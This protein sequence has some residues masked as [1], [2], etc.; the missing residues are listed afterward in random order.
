MY[1]R[2]RVARAGI[3]NARERR[4]CRRTAN[5][6]IQREI[7]NIYIYTGRERK[8]AVYYV[9]IYTGLFSTISR[10]DDCKVNGARVCL[11]VRHV[12]SANGARSNRT[13]DIEPS[14]GVARQYTFISLFPRC[15]AN[16]ILKRI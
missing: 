3:I 1:K 2:P 12:Y 14:Q 8:K 5:A 6:Y 7:E 9:Y 11:T 15:I 13:S 16:G 4:R 10:R